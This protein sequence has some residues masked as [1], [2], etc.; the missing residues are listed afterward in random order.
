MREERKSTSGAKIKSWSEL[1]GR[2]I[3]EEEYKEICQN[4]REFF[5]I[6]REWVEDEERRKN[7]EQEQSI[8]NQRP[9]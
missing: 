2:P 4:L 9:L 7:D 6:L 1:Y 8:P 5:S 3:S